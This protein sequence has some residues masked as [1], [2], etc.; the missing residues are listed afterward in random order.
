VPPHCVMHSSPPPAAVFQPNRIRASLR[1]IL[2]FLGFL[3]FCLGFSVFTLVSLYLLWFPWICFGVLL[4]C[5]SAYLCVILGFFAVSTDLIRAGFAALRPLHGFFRAPTATS[6]HYA[7]L[8]TGHHT[9]D[10]F[11]SLYFF[12]RIFS[13]AA[14]LFP[15]FCLLFACNNAL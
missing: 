14:F 1:L 15:I 10:W 3:L 11:L 5:F 7:L 2:C 12:L 9:S 8:C 13:F 4:Y 6:F